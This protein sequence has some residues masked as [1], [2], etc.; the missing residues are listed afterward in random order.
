VL[1]RSTGVIKKIFSAVT[2]ATLILA[3]LAAC[4]QQSSNNTTSDTTK[5]I[6]IGVSVPTSGDF[7]ADGLPTKQAY[8][9]WADTLNKQGGLLGR[10]IKLDILSDN[11][12]DESVTTAYRK[13]IN[14]DHV[15]LLIGPYAD[16]AVAAARVAS[17]SDFPI[18]DGTGTSA[19]DFTLGLTNMFSVSLSAKDYLKSFAE[20]ILSLPVSIRPKTAA[21]LGADDPFFTPQI[22]QAEQLLESGGVRTVLTFDQG[23]YQDETTDY[24]PYVQ[25]AIASH[26]DL[27]LVGSGTPDAISF[28]KGFKQQHYNPKAIV[29]ASG[30]DAGIQFTQP[31]GGANVAEGIFVPNGGW[32]PSF[33][34][35]QNSQFQSAYIAKFGG[36]A[37]DISSDTVQAYSTV[38]VLQQAVTKVGK[39]DNAAII[40]ELHTDTFNTLQGPVKF[41]ADGENSVS[42]AYLFQWQ[43]GA[44]IPVYPSNN[45]SANPEYPKPQWP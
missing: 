24:T 3:A 41:A 7:G 11:G 25:K 35:Y 33:S 21:Y 34:T 15:D 26:A 31:I 43:K 29:F 42:V 44:L 39:I 27:V 10:Q 36:K 2:I 38:Q 17:S 12:S 4:S 28:V 1:V 20:Y 30:P 18:I 9:L 5:P 8:Q 16:S 22:T 32:S 6:L 14:D 23:H 13:L 37:A 40:Q 19:A 45:A